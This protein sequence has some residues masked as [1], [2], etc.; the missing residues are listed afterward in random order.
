MSFKKLSTANTSTK[1]LGIIIDSR[2]LELLL[3]ED[4]LRKMID[5]L[6]QLKGRLNASRKELERVALCA[7]VIRRVRT[8]TR[9]I[10]D[11]IGSLREPSYKVR[12]TKGMRED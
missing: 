7:K 1:F 6:H 11:I 4:K 2:S 12:L 8:F 5:S 9:H 10:N 3:P